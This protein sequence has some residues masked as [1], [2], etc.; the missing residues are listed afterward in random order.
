MGL[1]VSA[2]THAPRAA[3]SLFRRIVRVPSWLRLVLVT[4]CL[5]ALAAMFQRE[6]V[7]ALLPWL[8]HWI[9][10]LD[11]T[12]RTVRLGLVQ[13]GADLALQRTVTLAQ[14]TVVGGQVLMPDPRGLGVFA[15]PAGHMLQPVVIASSLALAWPLR[16]ASELLLRL[17]MLVPALATV[18]A[19]DLPLTL[20]ALPWEVHVAAFEPDRFSPLLLWSQFLQG[21]GRLA[22]GLLAGLGAVLAADRLAPAWARVSGQLA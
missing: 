16:A 17:L 12:Y 14:V 3:T 13:G 20:V 1:C 15:V 19:V 9:A 11:A 10:W 5:T 7:Q 4:A 21:G 18:V 8:E 6:L 22:L 2:A